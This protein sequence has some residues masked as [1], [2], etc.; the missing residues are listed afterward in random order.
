MPRI[1]PTL[2]GTDVLALR[3]RTMVA[4]ID[5]PRLKTPKHLR[6]NQAWE[7]KRLGLKPFEDILVLVAQLNIVE[8]SL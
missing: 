2:S 5:P 3:M 1:V 6:L 8:R 4:E 7:I